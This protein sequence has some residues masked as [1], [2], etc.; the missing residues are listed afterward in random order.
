MKNQEPAIEFDRERASSYAQGWA[1]LAPTRAA[2][3]SLI[4]AILSDLPTDARI[5]CVGVGTGTELI[6]LAEAFPQLRLAVLFLASL[7]SQRIESTFV[8]KYPCDFARRGI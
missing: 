4:R 2:L 7:C 6:D 1:K 5:L 3:H 8:I